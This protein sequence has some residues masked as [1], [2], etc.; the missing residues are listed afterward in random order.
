MKKLTRV[1]LINWHRF[2]DETIEMGS[3]VLLSGENGAGKSTILD[4]IQFVLICSKT[5]FNKAAHEKGKRNLDSY[6]RCKTGR[7][8]RPYERTGALSG[9]IALEFYD[10]KKRQYFIVGA[11]LDSSSEEKEPNVA[12]YLMEKQRLEDGLFRKGK[13]IKSIS[14]FRSTNK[15]VRQWA[16]LPGE[17]KKIMKSRFGRLEDKFFSLIP[18]ALAFKPIHDIKEF[19]YSYVLDETEVNIDALKENVRSYQDLERMLRD[20]KERIGELE[21][22]CN[23]EAEVESLSSAPGADHRESDHLSSDPGGGHAGYLSGGIP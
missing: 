3:S 17:A 1:R 10:E 15:A 16:T 8:D 9:H 14:V 13:E 7:E 6:L 18:K 12:W 20:V 5:H 19:V 22:I 11:V 2:V 23:K 21:M 4:A